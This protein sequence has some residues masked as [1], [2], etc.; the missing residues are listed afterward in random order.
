MIR[1]LGSRWVRILATSLLITAAALS[2]GNVALF[3]V[4]VAI[5]IIAW[6]Y[7]SKY[8]L[9][10]SLGV[11]ALVSL[12]TPPIDIALTL[13]SIILIDNALRMGNE[14]PWWFYAT[15]PLATSTLLAAILRQFYIAASLAAPL[16]Y[17]LL[18]SL[19]NTIRFYTITIELKPSKSLRINAGSE[20]TYS[21][22]IITKPHIKAVMEVRA[23]RNLRISPTRLYLNGEASINVSARYSLGGVK[24][25]R[26]TLTFTDTYGLVRVRRVVRHPSITVI[27]RARTAIQFARGGL[28]AQSALTLGAEDIREVRE[29]VP[30]D[31]IRRLHWKKSAKLNRLIIKLLQG[32]GLT[33]PPI[34]LLSYATSSALIDRVGGEIFIYLTAELLTRIPRVDI[35]S[36]NRDGEIINYVLNRDNYFDMIERTLG[37]IENLNV[38]LVGGGDY[39]DVL[40]VIKYSMPLRIKGLVREG[41]ILIG[42]RLFVE[43]ICNAFKERV[44]CIPV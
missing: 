16:L 6:L 19:I 8:P 12:V 36:V 30:G 4:Y 25:P 3:A 41:T 35:I 9:P 10:L 5:T 26:L 23:P 38:R 29:Y 40:S 2:L 43:P 42:Q 17:I 7:W 11:T 39:A 14:K 31:P 24:R 15:P 32:P 37:S 20:L 1:E 28:L 44:V 21:L 22:T 33:G 27:P 34:V 13:I 18:I